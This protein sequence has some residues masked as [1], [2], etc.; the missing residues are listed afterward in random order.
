MPLLRDVYNAAQA[1]LPTHPEIHAYRV[2]IKKWFFIT[3][4]TETVT[5]KI[6]GETVGWAGEASQA[7]DSPLTIRQ[8]S[9]AGRNALLKMIGVSA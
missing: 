3:I 2:V 7:L 1:A 4:V 9:L 6:A 5:A 8:G